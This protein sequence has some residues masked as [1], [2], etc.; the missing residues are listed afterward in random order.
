MPR[1]Q[2]KWRYRPSRK[3][4]RGKKGRKLWVDEV[5]FGIEKTFPKKKRR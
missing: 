3:K 1:S 4:Y 2:Y 5:F